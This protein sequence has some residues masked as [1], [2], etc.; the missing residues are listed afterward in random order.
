MAENRVQIVISASG[1][2]EAEKLIA[3]V[4]TAGGQIGSIGGPSIKRAEDALDSLGGTAKRVFEIFAGVNLANVF[5]EGLVKM[6]EFIAESSKLGHENELQQA[7]FKAF[8]ASVGV[9]GDALAHAVEEASGR[10]IAAG[11]AMKVAMRGLSAGLQPEQIV[12]LTDASRQLAK[13]LQVDVVTAYQEVTQALATGRSRRLAEVGVTVNMQLALKTYADALG[14][15]ATALTEGQRTQALYNQFMQQALPVIESNRKVND[16]FGESMQR[17]K[18]AWVELEVTVGGFINTQALAVIQWL[19][20]VKAD[21]GDLT[22]GLEQLG[23]VW[24]ST[25]AV[26]TVNFGKFKEDVSGLKGLIKDIELAFAQVGFGIST[27][28]MVTAGAAAGIGSLLDDLGNKRIPDVGKAMETAVAKQKEAFASWVDG[29]KA[30]QDLAAGTT[31]ASTA[32]KELAASSDLGKN[33]LSDLNNQVNKTAD[34]FALLKRQIDV[35][36][37]GIDDFSAQQI[38]GVKDAVGARTMTPDQGAVADAAILAGKLSAQKAVVDDAIAHFVGTAGKAE[39]ERLQLLAQSLQLGTQLE[40]ANS[41]VR[42]VLWGQETADLKAEYAARAGAQQVQLAQDL[43]AIKSNLADQVAAYKGAFDDTVAEASA[44]GAAEVAAA[45]AT[46]AAT[47]ALLDQETIAQVEQFNKNLI[48]ANTF[49]ANIYAIAAKT[50]AAV[51]ALDDATAK[52]R[53]DKAAAND[54]AGLAELAGLL[55]GEQKLAADKTAL[56]QSVDA[57]Q[58]NKTKETIAGIDAILANGEASAEL[59]ESLITKKYELESKNRIALFQTEAD[60]RN[61]IRSPSRR[62]RCKQRSSGTPSRSGRRRCRS[63]ATPSSSA[64]PATTSDSS[65]R[66]SSSPSRRRRTPTTR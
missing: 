8:A 15:T 16:E 47:S 26:A 36:L 11:E 45:Q 48:S 5:E 50:S 1:A 31:A 62:P 27:L 46:F 3:A 38:I 6:R 39:E 13:S 29:R 24:A 19:G 22:P 10:T 9:A 54:A 66:S 60:K 25:W 18:V 61:E 21:L 56:W 2:A 7:T 28:F 51:L 4:A 58:I 40:K 57:F 65:A 41:A 30:L 35:A 42:L 34:G 52:A 64:R 49:Y 23:A 55:A 17:L 53:R 44:V 37:K 43:D 63:R 33:K 20:R 59:R 12:A 14:T 32:T